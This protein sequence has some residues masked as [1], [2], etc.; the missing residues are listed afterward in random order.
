MK[1][2]LM[3]LLCYLHQLVALFFNSDTQSAG[4]ADLYTYLDAPVSQES[5][6]VMQQ[7]CASD[8]DDL[9]LP[10]NFKV[11]YLDKLNGH[12]WTSK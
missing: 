1:T 8:P 11:W 4:K 6:M 2:T 10:E 3:I 9:T 12:I 7:F 5:K